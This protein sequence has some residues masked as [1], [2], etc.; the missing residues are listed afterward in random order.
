MAFDGIIFQGVPLKIRRPKDY[1]GPEGSNGAVH[2]PGV[3]S[4]TVQ[5]EL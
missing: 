1:V 4:T 5:G 2:I 3:V